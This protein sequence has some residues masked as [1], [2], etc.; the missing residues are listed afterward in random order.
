MFCITNSLRGKLTWKILQVA[1]ATQPTYFNQNYNSD[2]FSGRIGKF[3]KAS[4]MSE[5][6]G[7][8][9]MAVREEAQWE[10]AAKTL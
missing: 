2:R 7:D 10:T 3:F 1:N 9:D 5:A 4:L 6:A 8:P